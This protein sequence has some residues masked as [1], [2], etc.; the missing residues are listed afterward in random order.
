VRALLGDEILPGERAAPA[1]AVRQRFDREE[2][3]HGLA[4][5]RQAEQSRDRPRGGARPSTH[6]ERARGARPARV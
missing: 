4:G 3:R 1:L 2:E 5:L 6:G